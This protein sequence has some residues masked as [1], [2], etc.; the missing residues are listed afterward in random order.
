MNREDQMIVVPIRMTRSMLDLVEKTMTLGLFPE[1]RSEFIRNA[2]RQRV[3]R[4][5]D[6]KAWKE[7]HGVK[8]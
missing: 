2:V 1:N 6:T 3:T 5:M 4:E 7:I 8:R